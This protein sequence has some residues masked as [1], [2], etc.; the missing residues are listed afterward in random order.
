MMEQSP[1]FS[2]VQEWIYGSGEGLIYDANDAIEA[3]SEREVN[4]SRV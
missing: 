2:R 4:A 1:E 3:V